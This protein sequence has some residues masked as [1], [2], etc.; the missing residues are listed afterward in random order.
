MNLFKKMQELKQVYQIAMQRVSKL[1]E[2]DQHLIFDGVYYVKTLESKIQAWENNSAKTF[3]LSKE[4][5]EAFANTDISFSMAPADFKYPFD[6]FLIEGEVP[7]FKVSTFEG[8]S[9]SVD[10]ILY[11]TSDLVVKSAGAITVDL[12]GKVKNH[13]NWDHS[14]DA[15]FPSSGGVG[16]ERLMLYMRGEESIQSSLSVRKPGAMMQALSSEDAQNMV[17]IFFNTILYVNDP[18]RNVRET[19]RP[20]SRKLKINRKECKRCQYTYLTAPAAYKS[21]YASSGRTLD[22]RFIVRGHWRNQ[23]YGENRASRRHCWILPYWK[24]PQMSEI[25]SKPYM[26]Q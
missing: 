21:L 16:L 9:Q 24:G 14:L 26:V 12:D 3:I 10:S 19:E 13:C 4:L 6:A 18:T 20:G 17:N 23:A 7:L 8:L 11:V 5:I 1:P 2:K 25:V 15:F 22:K